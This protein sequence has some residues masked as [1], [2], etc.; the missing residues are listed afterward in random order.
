M[1]TGF[2]PL[3]NIITGSVILLILLFTTHAQAQ[4]TPLE[5]MYF[6]N[7]YLGN[8]A[9]AGFEQGL[10]LN[11]GYRK[12]WSSIPGAPKTQSIT[13]DYGTGKKVGLGLNINTDEAGLIRRTRVMGTYSY[14]LPLSGDNQKLRFG[15]SFG[16]MDAKV[17]NETIT[18]DQNDGSVSKFNARETYLDGDF[19][20]AY[21]SNHLTIQGAIPNMK[22][23][24]K[25]DNVNDGADRSTFF[26]AISYTFYL[27]KILDGIGV[28]PKL[29]YR[30]VNG[31]SNILDVGANFTIVN[32]KVSLMS[33]YHSS[34]SATFGMGVIIKDFGSIT[35]NYTTPT[36]ALSP[37]TNGIFQIGLKLNLFQKKI[38]Q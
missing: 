37:Y 6:A 11:M 23:F 38:D 34:Q 30:G 1:K 18:G 10:N 8:P 29:V 22:G 31:F 7:Q 20:V 9:M 17:L 2:K 33:M 5:D 4:L 35:S 28:E 26:S 36:S 21:T 12:Q 14:Q 19:G 16:F 24:V 32:G 27:P 13:A 3:K 15:I 25:K